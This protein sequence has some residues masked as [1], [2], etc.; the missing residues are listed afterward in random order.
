[1]SYWTVGT[2][3]EPNLAT[4][5]IDLQMPSTPPPPAGGHPQRPRTPEAPPTKPA[6][7]TTSVQQPHTVPDRLPDPGPPTPTA[8]DLPPGLP[9]VGDDFRTGPI[10]NGD[11]PDSGP[12]LDFG[13]KGDEAPIHLTAEMSRPRPLQPIS[14][15]YTE[16]ARR[17]GLQGSVIVQAVI[18]EHGRATDVRILRGLPMGLDRAAV[19]AI[20]RCPFEPARIG[21]RPVKVYFNLTVNFTIQR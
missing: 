8:V 10:G 14:P 2:V 12:A 15:K 19:E 11:G 20:E 7:A 6:T 3:P 4:A 13:P 16:I 18:D 21:S 1:G 5:F 17:A 9:V